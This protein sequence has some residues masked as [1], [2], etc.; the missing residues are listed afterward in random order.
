MIKFHLVIIFSL[1]FN[2]LRAQDVIIVTDTIESI[3]LTL[4]GMENG[5]V[6]PIDIEPKFPGGDL[7]LYAFIKMNLEYPQD[8]VQGI[9]YVKFLI[10]ECGEIDS[11]HVIRGIN[12]EMD[13]AAINVIRAMPN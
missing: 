5:I 7:A 2:T 11:I 12:E 10:T 4:K 9:V 8:C 13:R 6:N 1:L 3:P